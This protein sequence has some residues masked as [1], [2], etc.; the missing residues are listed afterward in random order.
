MYLVEHEW[1]TVVLFF[2]CTQ[3]TLFHYFA[4]GCNFF[5]SFLNC[6]VWTCVSVNVRISNSTFTSVSVVVIGPCCCFLFANLALQLRINLFIHARIR[7]DFQKVCL[8]RSSSITYF[9]S[10]AA[11]NKRLT[12]FAFVSSCFPV[13][14]TISSATVRDKVA[15]QDPLTTCQ[16]G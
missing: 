10:M 7:T 4:C 5:W 6:S 15:H 13:C 16:A 8:P 9:T 12:N 11:V 3:K 14:T 1:D 2:F